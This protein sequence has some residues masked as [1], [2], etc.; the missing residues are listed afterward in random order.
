MSPST[1]HTWAHGY[2]RR[3]LGRPGVKQGPVITSVRRPHD[4]RT[5]PFIG[6]VEATVVQAFRRS[7]LSMQRIRRALEV[8]AHESE[9]EHALASRSVFTDGAHVLY[10]YARKQGDGQ[11]RL[12]TV[13]TSGQIVFHDLISEYLTRITFGDAWATELFVPVTRRELLRIRPTVAAGTPLFVNGG[14]P[15][16]AVRSRLLAG[17]PAI[18]IADDYQVPVADINEA[19]NAISAAGARSLSPA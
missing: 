9:L 5:I 2:E 3:P 13:V 8:L 7:D 1:L 14:A 10:D 16:S 6:L 15:L 19:I 11:L 12:L 4:D 17:E 18:S